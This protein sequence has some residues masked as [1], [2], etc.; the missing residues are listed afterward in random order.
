M[1]FVSFR[2]LKNEEAAKDTMQEAFLKAFLNLEAYK[3]NIRFGSWLKK[4]VI[5][6]C[7]DALRKKNLTTVSIENDLI[8][9]I[10][11]EDWS[12]QVEISKEQ[13]IAAIET[14]KIK[15]QLVLKLYL[16]EGYDHSE[17]SE[18]LEIPIKISRTQLRRGKSALQKILKAQKYGT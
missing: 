6:T 7:I 12:C 8:E 10:D 9:I 3:E 2:Y 15:Y 13:I 1:F 17:I 4:I 14:L 11:D 18:I 5:N 16:I